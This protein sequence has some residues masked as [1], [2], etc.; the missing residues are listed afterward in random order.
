MLTGDNPEV[1]WAE[2]TILSFAVL[3][4]NAI[5][6]HREHYR[7][8]YHCT[9]DLLFDWFGISCMTADNFCVYWQN[10]LIQTGQA[11]G[12]WNSDTSPFSIP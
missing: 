3:L 10:R 5:H 8:K 4:D 1:L 11:G 9:I 12:Q 6:V 7:G 2:F